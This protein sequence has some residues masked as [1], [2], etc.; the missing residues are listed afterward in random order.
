MVD[1]ERGLV[2]THRVSLESGVIGPAREKKRPGERKGL[3]R[4]GRKMNK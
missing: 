2:K 4:G 3:E 1:R